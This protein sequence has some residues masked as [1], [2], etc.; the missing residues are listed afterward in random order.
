MQ[1]EENS[2][3]AFKHVEQLLLKE[4]HVKAGDLTIL[5]AGTPVRRKGATNNLRI[6][7]VGDPL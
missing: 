7:R 2:D 4:K 1:E 5:I 6:H 3:E